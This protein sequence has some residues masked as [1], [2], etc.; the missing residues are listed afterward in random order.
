LQQNHTCMRALVRVDRS[1]GEYETHL[2]KLFVRLWALAAGR[3]P[4]AVDDKL[5]T[6]SPSVAAHHLRRLR[7]VLVERQA[8]RGFQFA[9][10]THCIFPFART[11]GRRRESEWWRDGRALSIRP[12]PR[13]H[14]PRSRRFHALRS[15]T[16]AAAD[17]LARRGLRVAG[18]HARGPGRGAR[19]AR[20]G[21]P[22]VRERVVH[23]A[24]AR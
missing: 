3:D 2:E 16:A 17:R 12:S 20:W 21:F 15:C 9:A 11:G 22:E 24:L 14:R 6:G 8:R 7:R 5:R 23:V 18:G 1:R 10:A 4:F 19:P 13:P